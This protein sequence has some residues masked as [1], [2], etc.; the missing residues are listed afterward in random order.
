MPEWWIRTH[1]R[2]ENHPGQLSGNA[3]IAIMFG[4]VSQTRK[5]RAG[6]HVQSVAIGMFIQDGL[7]RSGAKSL[8]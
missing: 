5:G 3:S 1:L 2:K 6:L 7:P 4:T 8:L